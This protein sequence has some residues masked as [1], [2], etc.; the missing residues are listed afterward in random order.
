[1][2]TGKQRRYLR[3]MGT[4]I[5]PIIHIGK[6]GLVDSLVQQL[7]DALEARELIKVRVIPNAPVIPKE[8]APQLADAVG[9][10]LVQIVGRNIL[11]YRPSQKK[12]T[13]VLP[14]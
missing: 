6:A 7:S 4:G 8:I 10:E 11:F 2:L 5:D 9:A 13:I 12:P 3:A 1:M 14:E